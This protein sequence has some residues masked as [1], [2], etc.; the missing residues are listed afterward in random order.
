MLRTMDYMVYPGPRIIG[1]SACRTME[2]TCPP[3]VYK[4]HGLSTDSEQMLL[5][6]HLALSG[7]AAY[8]THFL[9]LGSTYFPVLTKIT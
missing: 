2:Y 9:V 8:I 5:M 6:T 7:R 4:Q 1:G 3:P